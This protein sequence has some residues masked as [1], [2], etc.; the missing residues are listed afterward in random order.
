MQKAKP[1]FCLFIDRLYDEHAIHLNLFSPQHFPYLSLPDLKL[2]VSLH[3]RIQGC[4]FVKGLVYVIL[5]KT[6][7]WHGSLQSSGG[8]TPPSFLYLCSKPMTQWLFP[9][10]QCP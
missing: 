4:M 6:Y 2:F 1:M 5:N 7:W 8:G 10:L 3:G 9:S